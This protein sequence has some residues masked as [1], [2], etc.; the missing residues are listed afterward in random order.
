MVRGLLDLKGVVVVKMQEPGNLA[1]KITVST[2]GS[3]TQ[4]D[5]ELLSLLDTY[6]KAVH[7]L[8]LQLMKQSWREYKNDSTIVDTVEGQLRDTIIN[9]EKH[10]RSFIGN[11]VTVE[12]ILKPLKEAQKVLY[13]AQDLAERDDMSCYDEYDKCRDNIY[14]AECLMP[15]E[16]S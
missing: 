13:K 12:S 10:R 5:K 9:L 14:L 16:G 15:A 11:G 1:K 7:E 2:T 4:P 8:S 3:K 6:R